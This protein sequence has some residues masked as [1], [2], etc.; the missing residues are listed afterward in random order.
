MLINSYENF[1][2]ESQQ[3]QESQREELMKIDN[4]K[5]KERKEY[6]VQNHLIIERLNKEI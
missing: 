2:K 4:L 1:K 5:D 6:E 3:I